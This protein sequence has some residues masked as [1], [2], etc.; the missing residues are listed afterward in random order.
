M[1]SPQSKGVP[2]ERA[3]DTIMAQAQPNKGKEVQVKE[4]TLLSC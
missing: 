4:I 1:T 3:I 2:L